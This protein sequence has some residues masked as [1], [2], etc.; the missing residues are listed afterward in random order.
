MNRKNNDAPLKDLVDKLMKAYNLDGRMKEMNI[1][2][3]WEQIVGPAIFRRTESIKLNNRKLI[4]TLKSSVMRDELIMIKT[5]LIQRVNEF[6]KEE[7][8]DDIWFS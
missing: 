8:V 1:V 6:A 5:E 3:N 2:N 4:L 7:L